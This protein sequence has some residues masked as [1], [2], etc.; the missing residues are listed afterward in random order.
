MYP[1]YLN[2]SKKEINHRVKKLFKN[3]ENCEICPRKCHVNR[4]KG[5][6]GFCQLTEKPIVSAYHPHFGE[7]AVLVGKY[8]SGTIFLTSCN[9]ACVYCR[10]YEISQLR[11][12]EEVSFERLAEGNY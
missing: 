1:S 3:L 4:L 6:K 9:L 2:L 8:G 7:E 11:I 10:N 5:E 12:G